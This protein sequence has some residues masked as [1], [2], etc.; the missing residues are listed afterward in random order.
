[1][2]FKKLIATVTATVLAVSICGCGKDTSAVYEVK[3]GKFVPLKDL[4]LTVWYTQGTDYTAGN[5]LKD[6][7]VQKYVYDKTRITFE[8]TYGN[9]G[10]QWDT[11]LS[12]LLTGD[13]MPDAVICG[14]GQG[15]TH[16]A[17]LVKAK[18][19]WEI[20]DDLLEKYAPNVLKRI[21]K[22]M[23]DG[24]KINGKLYGIP[25]ALQEN[26][27]T[28]QPSC[29]EQTIQY[30]NEMQ[31]KQ[32]TDE[33]M[34]MYVRDDILKKV[35]PS[36]KTWDEIT[37]LSEKENGPIADELFD[38]G[39]NTTQD[40]IDFM[41]KIKN[42]NLTVNGKP[43]YAFGYS[44]GDNWE[45]LSYLGADMMG[46]A[47]LTYVGAWDIDK[48]EENILIDDDI[49]KE[50]ASIQ[51]K[52]IRDSVID[53][54]SIMHTSDMYKEKVNNGQYAICCINYAGGVGTVNAAL[55]KAG[56]PYRYRPLY[57]NI[58][59]KP[60][61]KAAATKPTWQFSVAFT[62]SLTEDEFIQ[63]L[64]WVNVCFSDEF[65]EVFYWGTKEDGL[66]TENE[67][68]TRTYTDERFAKRFYEGDISALDD[69]LTKGIGLNT[70]TAGTWYTM[71]T[72]NSRWAPGIYNHNYKLSVGDSIKRYKTDSEHIVK[73]SVPDYSPW[74]SI[75]SSNDK[76]ITFWAKR[77]QWE[78]P[79]KL[80]F[81]A[82]DDKE[83]ESKWNDAL[84]KLNDIVDIKEMS[85]EMTEI[86]NKK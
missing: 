15:P 54:E 26:N 30:I 81:A 51:N 84:K 23:L 60:E 82:K 71:A 34:A 62:K 4:P 65:E 7:V 27:K 37:A 86:A 29:D 41:Y 55:K 35:Y 77:E 52:M 14:A 45:A 63:A 2:K 20:S 31:A 25:Y 48:N 46:Y 58:P 18:Q 61:Y 13:N 68:G 17:K 16:F 74:S 42:M 78:N 11:K 80:A 57:V 24:F 72:Q 59:N 69:S 12:R 64:N 83:F 53:P 8:N 76:V 47:P 79:F 56:K 43:V 38:T 49:I 6:N 44:G 85:K 21:P 28:T 5:E 73:T 40:Y 19:L 33:Q 3:D 39:I 36:A 70:A 66:Y 9:D 10:G 50:A 22:D 32:Y 67:D 1:M 75:Y